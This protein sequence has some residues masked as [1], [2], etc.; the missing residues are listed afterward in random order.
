MRTLLL[1]LCA[2]APL[3]AHAEPKALTVLAASSLAEPLRASAAAFEKANPGAKVNVSAAATGVLAKQLQA[4]APCD[5]FIGAAREQVDAL[6][7]NGLLAAPVRIARN[8]LVVAAPATS[9]AKLSG[10]GDLA[11]PEF[12]RIALGQPKLVPAGDYARE[13]LTKLGLLEVLGPKL[14]YGGNVTQVLT[15]LRSGDVDA[16]F[17]YASDLHRAHGEAKVLLAI[18]D[19]LH[20]PIVYPA[21]VATHGANR[22]LA[23]AYIAFLRGPDGLRALASAGFAPP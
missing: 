20:A 18:P 1:V 8:R 12:R 17:V 11:H 19:D 4:G 21:A 14:V 3:L 15:Y 7:A 5:V 2:S 6:V 9:K 23:A 22:A 10:L 16:G 13:A